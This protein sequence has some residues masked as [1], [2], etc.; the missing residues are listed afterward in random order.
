MKSKNTKKIEKMKKKHGL[1]AIFA[2]IL[3][4][5]VATMMLSYFVYSLVFY[6]LEAKLSSEYE[7]ISYMARIY[8]QSISEDYEGDVWAILNEDGREYIIRDKNGNLLVGDKDNTCSEDG[9]LVKLSGIDCDVEV[10]I[11][12]EYPFVT[13]DREGLVTVRMLDLLDYI[14]DHRKDPELFLLIDD[15]DVSTD[16]SNVLFF[17][18]DSYLRLPVWMGMK[19]A[20]GEETF[21][22]KGFVYIRMSDVSIVLI[23]TVI[24]GI[25]FFIIF[26]LFLV[27][28][29]GNIKS[30]KRS[31]KLFFMDLA[32]GGHNRMWYIYKGEALL[33]KRSSASYQYAVVSLLSVKYNTFCMCHSVSEGEEIIR[34][35]SDCIGRHITRHEVFAHESPESFMLLL[36]VKDQDELTGRLGAIISD[37]EKIDNNHSF[38]YHLGV[39]VL[40]PPRDV[41]GRVLRRRYIDLE[42][43]YN[44]AV[45][46]RNTLNGKEDSGVAYF[47]LKLV[48]E[49]KWHDQV[50]EHCREALV[51]QEFLVY[52][53]PKYDPVTGLM[54]GT[55]ALIRW[56]SPTLGFVS[57][58]KFIPIFEHNG[59][60]TEIDHYMLE[61]VAMDQKKW[62]DEGIECVPISVNIS[63][64]HFI[65][66]D[67]AEQIRDTM[68]RAGAPRNLIEIELT[69]SAFFDDKNALIKTISKL[70][71]Y[72]FA[73]SM[74]DFGSGY[75]SLNSLKDM[76]LDILK[77][78]AEFFRGDGQGERGK[79][80]VSETIKLARSLNMRTVAEGVEIKE[81][82]DFL[83][84]HG[85]DMIQGFYYAKPMPADEYVKKLAEKKADK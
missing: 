6:L 68:D 38:T 34:K 79:I 5:V 14:Q 42:Q 40:L 11:D 50:E 32:T 51:N 80:V 17:E 71:E 22:G 76:P 8:E 82:V 81:Q 28:M 45:T 58:G 1:L 47:D 43:D 72:G 61:R 20:G 69:E 12:K 46:A 75:S 56:Q 7:S 36:R 66:S 83:A 35:V 53:Q 65:E 54:R 4:C 19:V 30:Q 24:L 78:D 57:P 55:E 13:L 31:M 25:L 63:R 41:N 85:C 59:F 9:D 44:N 39:S 70:K 29:I 48:E 49:R 26:M 52:Y 64:A 3:T 74:D 60:I 2:F 15:G 77:L 21:I 37:L 23:T 62:M 73:V 18:S 27:N 10:F 84:E 67:L 16:T 33:K